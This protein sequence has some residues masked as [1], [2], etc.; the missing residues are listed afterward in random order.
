MPRA[1]ADPLPALKKAI[2]AALLVAALVFAAIVVAGALVYA[3]SCVMWLH[4]PVLQV[5]MVTIP[6]MLVL[7][8][9]AYGC[10]RV[11]VRLMKRA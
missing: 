11:G 9:L 8:A 4:A 10:G 3:V 5:F 7:L 2:G 1:L 6:L